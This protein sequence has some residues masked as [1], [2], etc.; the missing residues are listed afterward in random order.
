MV[1]ALKHVNE[2]T[3]VPACVKDVLNALVDELISVRK[4]RDQL[5]KENLALRRKFGIPSELPI[6]AI[7][8]VTASDQPAES[9]MPM[10]P[11]ST[12]K[13]VRHDND[14]RELERKRSIV[15][16]GVPELKSSHAG[17]RA[18]YDLL[19]VRNVLAHIGVQ[20]IPVSVYRL[21]RPAPGRDRL[22]KEERVRRRE[23]YQAPVNARRSASKT[24]HSDEG[25]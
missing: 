8:S 6:S 23:M 16:S 17:E 18:W 14:F 4:E 22:L 24:V 2:S 9:M 3:K 25:N 19:S 13:D 11:R 5:L 7:D 12:S 10:D 15:I 20:C 1:S 21:G